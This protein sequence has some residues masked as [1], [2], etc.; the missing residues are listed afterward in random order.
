[1]HSRRDLL[2]NCA[3]GFA[4]AVA[5]LGAVVAQFARAGAAPGPAADRRDRTE[6][7]R[8]RAAARPAPASAPAAAWH[9]VLGPRHVALPP[10]DPKVGATDP[11]DRLLAVYYAEHKVPAAASVDDRTYARRVT[12]DLVGTLPTESELNAFVADQSPDKRRRLV[13]RLLGDGT[14]YAEHW[15]SFWN[16]MLRNDYA[17]TGYIDGGRAQISDWLYTALQNNMPYDRF[18]TEL[19]DPKPQSAGFVKGIVWRGVVNASQTPEMQAAQNI[20]QVFLGINLKCA[21][22]HNSFISSWKLAD[23]YGMAGIYAGKPLQMVRCDKPTGQTAPVKFLF[24]E[25]GGIDSSAPQQVQR[26][27]LAAILTNPA[28]GR[29]S[30]VVVNRIWTKLMGRGLVEPNDDMDRK[31]WDPDLLDWL[32]D[33]FAR[34][35]YD[36]RRLM[37]QIATSRAYQRPVMTLKSERASNFVFSGPAVK[38]MSAEQFVDAVSTLTGSWRQPAQQVRFVNGEPQLPSNTHATVKYKSDVM[39]YGSVDI[40]VDCSGATKLLLVVG[41]AGDGNSF[42]WADWADARVVTPGGEIRLSTLKPRA[43]STGFGQVELNRS[44]AKKPLRLA[45]R[46]YANG[47]GVHANSALTYDLPVGAT[48]FR[49]TAGPDAGAIEQPGSKTSVQLCVIVGDESLLRGRAALA[50]SDA[51]TRALDRPNREQ[52]VTQRA[53][54]AT[55]L[56]ALEL[57]NG[58]TLAGMLSTGADSLAR[59][60]KSPESLVNGLYVQALDRLPAPAEK[61][62]A[63]RAVGAPASRDGVEDLLWALVMLPEFQL[64]Y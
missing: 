2:S 15:L 27:Q 30:R 40:D 6:P 8:S 20:S 45:D 23:A 10:A 32:A 39:R 18:V 49:A 33:D 44:V 22:C 60:A 63:L 51:L 48:R 28:D 41:D 9:A 61:A 50:T 25:L 29:L 21:S 54:V 13:V 26:S 36:L 3:R 17:G 1:M 52:V 56:Q 58:Q 19:V 11:I 62:A 14:R 24:P 16:D 55:T 4:V 12:L 64:I 7:A 34:N 47:I 59:S 57:T 37:L 42:D 43:A 35:G 53:T 5:T 46:T 31:P 38:R